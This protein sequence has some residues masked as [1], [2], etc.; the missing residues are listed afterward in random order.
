MKISCITPDRKRDFLCETILEGLH[1]LGHDLIVS[2]PG[3]GFCKYTMIDG[4]FREHLQTSDLL[5]C[6]FGKVRDN[7]P[8]RRYFVTDGGFPREKI[9]YIDGSEWNFEGNSTPR[10]VVDSL[11]DPTKRRGE[12]WIDEEMME[13]C[14]HYFKREAYPYD[15]SHRGVIPLP[16]A[17]CDRHIV[18][19]HAKDIDVFCSFGQITTGLRREALIAVED[20]RTANPSLNIVTRNDLKPDEYK[21]HLGR[22]RVVVDAW[23]G[24]DTCD[25]FWE[26]IGAGACVL[27]QR[28]NIVMPNPF[29]DFEHAV[30]FSSMSEFSDNLQRLVFNEG[31]SE[32]I[33]TNGLEHA[34][35]FHFAKH[36]AERILREFSTV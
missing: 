6:F 34:V 5:L 4:T 24:G 10:Q 2:D 22:S 8:P 23:G 16:F 35:E 31:E 36:R 27:Y 26:G 17:L 12:P 28:Y 14:G 7:R 13:Q 9:A 19:T 30:S 3:N 29:V 1:E 25:R 11:D 18:G 32:S 20:F 33:T 21:E 15:V